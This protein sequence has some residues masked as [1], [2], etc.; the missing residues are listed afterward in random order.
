MPV[1][2]ILKARRDIPF[3]LWPSAHDSAAAMQAI[4]R[5]LPCHCSTKPVAQEGN[6]DEA[7]VFH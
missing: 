3:T 7:E 4:A 1:E 6:V 5:A 2:F